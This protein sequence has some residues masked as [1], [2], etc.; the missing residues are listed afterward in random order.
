[1]RLPTWFRLRPR[2]DLPVGSTGQGQVTNVAESPTRTVNY[3][4]N[5]GKRAFQRVTFRPILKPEA[6]LITA[7]G[8]NIAQVT[9]RDTMGLEPL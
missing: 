2:L 3:K 4:G 7:N 9:R 8:C 1:M 5:L 6:G